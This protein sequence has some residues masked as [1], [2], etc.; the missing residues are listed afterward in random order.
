MGY[1]NN[2]SSITNYS[3]F[4]EKNS[5]Y[6]NKEE[7]QSSSYKDFSRDTFG[8]KKLPDTSEMDEAYLINTIRYEFSHNSV[9]DEYKEKW[10]KRKLDC[11]MELMKRWTKELSEN[12]IFPKI[13]TK[14]PE[15]DGLNKTLLSEYLLFNKILNK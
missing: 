5:I 7:K 1:N 13:I 3:F 14:E 2:N 11:K 10:N 8:D 9:S 12:G 15:R 4:N 6:K